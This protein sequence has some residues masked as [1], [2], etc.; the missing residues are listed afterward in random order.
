MVSEIRAWS[1]TIIVAILVSVIIESLIPNG[2]NK[3]YIKVIIG[4]YI[5]FVTF[6]PI[7]SI[8]DT[9]F[10]FENFIFESALDKDVLETSVDMKSVYITG[11]EE[12]IKEDI[13]L[14]G[15]HLENVKIKLD[16]LCENIILIEL[17]NVSKRKNKIEIE[18]V[19]VGEVVINDKYQD[20][21]SYLIQNYFVN[22]EN[23]VFKN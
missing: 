23:I 2:N 19:K 17:K 7:L 6:D 18:E 3:K 13:K 15:Y 11:I 21:Y 1:E 5:M 14:L 12:T 4:I 20:I 22:E 9:D 10:N 8:F 16:N